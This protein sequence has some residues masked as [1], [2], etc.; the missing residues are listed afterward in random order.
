MSDNDS[1]KSRAERFF[2]EMLPIV[3]SDFII[4]GFV[5]WL[6]ETVI[7]SIYYKEFVN[8]G[9]LPIPILPIYGLF[10]LILPFFYRKHKHPL[11]VLI[12]SSIAAT[13]FELAGAY[14]TEAILHKRL[15]DY[16]LWPLSF[17][18]DRVSLFFSLIFGLLCVCYVKGFHPF[19]LFLHKKFG[20]G[21]VIGLAILSA[22][23]IVLCFV[24]K[25]SPE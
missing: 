5:G 13:V 25:K 9:V 23:L 14:L 22:I 4:C 17:F 6:Y 20:K 16:S 24:I 18:D 12:T 19:S 3:V 2:L 15:W 7:T 10:S 1:D 11:F 8:R 21:F